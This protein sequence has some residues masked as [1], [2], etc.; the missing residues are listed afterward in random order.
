[1]KRMKHVNFGDP[2]AYGILSASRI[3]SHFISRA[4]IIEYFTTGSVSKGDDNDGNDANKKF[5]NRKP[6]SQ[7]RRVS[8]TKTVNPKRS[9]HNVSFDQKSDR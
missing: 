9:I 6:S 7:L 4:N 2:R 5:T 1:M 8:K 3:G